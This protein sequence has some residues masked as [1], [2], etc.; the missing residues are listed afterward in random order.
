M[1]QP[2]RLQTVHHFRAIDYVVD[3]AEEPLTE[4]IIK[5]LHQ[6]IKSDTKDSRLSWFAVGDYKKSANVVGGRETV[7]PKDVPE[8]IRKLLAEY[9]I[10]PAATIHD[11]IALYAEFEYNS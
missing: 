7:K 8:A 9:N 6:I 5:H 10:K 2:E 1:L 11:I 3:T 4:E